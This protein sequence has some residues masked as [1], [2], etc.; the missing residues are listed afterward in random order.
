MKECV[1]PVRFQQPL[2]LE[3]S[4]AADLSIFYYAR[5]KNGTISVISTGGFSL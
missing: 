4:H 5:V 3:T 1:L 2:G